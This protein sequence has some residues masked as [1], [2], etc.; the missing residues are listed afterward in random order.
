MSNFIFTLLYWTILLLKLLVLWSQLLDAHLNLKTKE[1]TS[2][3]WYFY[4]Q[5]KFFMD[6][7]RFSIVNDVKTVQ[8]R[9][10]IDFWLESGFLGFQWLLNC[11]WGEVGGFPEVFKIMYQISPSF[12]FQKCTKFDPVSTPKVYWFLS[13]FHP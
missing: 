7:C 3:Y 2:I 13:S 4:S 5:A 12:L 1:T 10:F 6:Y 9:C 8:I 11:C